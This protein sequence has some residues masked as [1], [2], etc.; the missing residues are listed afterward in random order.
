MTRITVN[1]APANIRKSGP[2]FDFPIAI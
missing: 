2:S 1:L